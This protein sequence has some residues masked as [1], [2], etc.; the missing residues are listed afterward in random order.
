MPA[1]LA[2]EDVSEDVA[3]DDDDVDEEEAEEEEAGATWVDNRLEEEEYSGVGTTGPGE[4]RGYGAGEWSTVSAR[5]MSSTV[6]LSELETV[7]G[8]GGEWRCA[9]RSPEA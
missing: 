4:A 2:F 7:D 6:R 5:R 1:E 9:E 8:N 3:D